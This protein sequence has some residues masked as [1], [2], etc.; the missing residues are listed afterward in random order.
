MTDK[1]GE[2]QNS[3]EKLSKEQGQ[4]QWKW[5]KYKPRT[6][7]P[8]KKDPE[9][10][11]ILKYGPQGNF[12]K[13]KEAISKTALR[14][15]GHLDE[16]ID[17]GQYYKPQQPNTADYDFVNDPCGL[18][19]ALFMEAVKDH[20]K[21]LIKMNADWP[22][23]YALIMQY[24]SDE[25]LDEVKRVATFEDIKKATDPL[26]LWKLVEESHKVNSISKVE[27]VTKLAA[28]TTY[29]GMRQGPYETIIQYK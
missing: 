9:E 16:L 26:E 2:K 5:H 24:L 8:K 21:E 1:G 14:D 10:L 4:P 28:W 7:Q 23:L 12:A 18:N 27:A 19:K 17:T 22:K 20:R 13:F 15:Y 3:K 29:Q 25:S 6:D 11:P